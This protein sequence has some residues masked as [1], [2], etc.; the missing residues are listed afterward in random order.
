MELLWTN[1][2]PNSSFIAQNIT[3]ENGLND[4]QFFMIETK[5]HISNVLSSVRQYIMAPTQFTYSII[6]TGGT[7]NVRQ[8]FPI[9]NG[10]KIEASRV[11]STGSID[12]SYLIPLRIF[13]IKGDIN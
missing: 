11:G 7:Y 2:N 8:V 5:G 6:A 9:T 13:G 3:F 12:N 10:I 1:P 4:Y